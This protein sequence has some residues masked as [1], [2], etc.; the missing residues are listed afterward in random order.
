MYEKYNKMYNIINLITPK[1]LPL[2]PTDILSFSF[3]HDSIFP[4]IPA[5]KYKIAKLNTLYSFSRENPYIT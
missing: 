4:N 5:A 1:M 2:A 3:T